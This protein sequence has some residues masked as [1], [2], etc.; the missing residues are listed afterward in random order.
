MPRKKRAE[1]TRAPNMAATIYLGKDGRWHGR[2][3]MGVHDNGT[4]DRRHVS[5]KTEGDVRDKIRDLEKDRDAGRIKR[6]G[7]AW[8]VE[9]WLTHWLDN[10]AAH[11]VRPKTLA[12][13][14]TAIRRHLIPGL[15]AHRTDR[16]QPEHLER[17]YAKLSASGLRPATVHQI[18]RTLRTAL[19]EAMRRGQMVRNPASVAKSP[20]L[21]EEEIDP[22]TVD[23]AR[24]VL[25]VAHGKRNGVRF[26]LALAVGLRQGEALGLKWRDVDPASGTLTI[27]RALQRHTWQHGCGGACGRTRGTDCPKRHG[28]GLAEVPT[29]SRAGRR[30]VG[31]PRPL[32]DALD[33]HRK[34]QGKERETA[35]DL[36]ED[37]DWVFAQPTGRPIDPRVDYAEWRRLLKEA[38]VRPARLHDARHTAATML[39]V[40]KVPT[41]AVM[42][43]MGWSQASMATRYQ[44]VPAE[45]LR[46]IADQMGGLLWA[47]DSDDE[48]PKRTD[49]DDEKGSRSAA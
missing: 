15:G 28:G 41:R 47:A 21:V 4:P 46:G 24:A 38:G 43:V 13:Y 1:G 20:R 48:P 36:W 49:D 7:R 25:D 31:V 39:L 6:P 22:L 45:V 16:L 14:Q 19:N 10:I 37:G 11:S 42:D 34:A 18:H 17:F 27:R 9:K 32:M 3:T 26:A 23:E 30:V 2:V 5:A 44:H 12:G 35:A 8:T 29:K 40:L 33:D